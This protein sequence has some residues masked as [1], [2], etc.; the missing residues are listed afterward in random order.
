[1][2]VNNKTYD[3]TTTATGTAVINGKIEGDDVD[4]VG[5]AAFADKNVG[6]GKPITLGEY[7]LTGADSGNYTLSAQPESVTAD[8]LGMID[9]VLIPAGTFRMG[10]PTNEPN[11]IA[12]LNRELQHQVTLTKSFYMGK[13][14]VTQSQ[15]VE[16]MGDG[17]DRTTVERGKGDNYPIYS[18][19]WY[20]AIVF[21]NKLSM[22][23]NLDPVYSIDG[24]TDPADWGTIYTTSSNAKW[25]AVEIA[26]GS[27]GY[28][29]PTE[30][31]W[32]YACRGDYPNKA[33]ET[34]TKPFGIGDG[35]KMISD[36]AN[37]QGTYPYDMKQSGEYNDKSGTYL[38]KTTEVGSYEPNNY[39]LYDMHGNLLEW[40]R[41][42]FVAN[43]S[44][45]TTDPT[46]PASGTMRIKRGGGY[47][48]YAKN[49]RS[50]YRV[51]ENP[52]ERSN[53]VGIR[54][55]RSSD[56]P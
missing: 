32:E 24:K 31:E 20:D 56:T 34:A 36:M 8:I 49:M 21:C 14:L 51:A 5:T 48:D 23:E 47:S 41:D 1:V 27:N 7:S 30:A 50:A 6:T 3:G 19:N 39:G 2:N 26:A 29:L 13:Y 16:V 33:T 45:Y 18:V 10:S 38:G 12:T 37:F 28:R 40:C 46:G 52:Y 44:S 25:D 4:A 42:W 54:L 53:D 17:E 43:I 11:R 22:I 9:M 15:W 55:V 35:T